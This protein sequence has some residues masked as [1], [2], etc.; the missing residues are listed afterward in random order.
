MIG[1][2]ARRLIQAMFVV[3]A[4]SVIVFVGLNMIG[5]PVE[6]LLPPDATQQD[7]INITQALGLDRP[8]IEQYGLF[9]MRALGGDLGVSFIFNRPALPLILERLPATLELAF[10]AVFLSILIGLP[11]GIFAGLKPEHPFSKGMMGASI[12]GFS[13]PNF[14]VGLLLIMLFSVHLGWLPSTGRGET[15]ELFGIQWSFLTLDGLRHLALPATNLALFNIAMI[16][17]LAR[18]V[19]RETMPMDF[20]KFAVAKG[21]PRHRVIGVH[22]L[23]NIMIPIVTVVGLEFGSTVAF[24]IVTETIFAWPGTGKLVIDSINLLDRPVVVAYLI[25]V[26]ILFVV[27]NLIVDLLYTVLDPRIRLETKE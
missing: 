7:R 24:A 5:D 14:W 4:M 20:M 16:L 11:L 12:L 1:W 27:V 10:A 3:A 26:V 23:K 8:L 17:R 19:V 2:I 13:L 15:A 22:L 6:F 9:V 21:L 25:I 18:A